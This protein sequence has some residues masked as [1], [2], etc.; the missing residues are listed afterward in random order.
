MNE[1]MNEWM[2]ELYCKPISDETNDRP[3]NKTLL[4]ACCFVTKL[5]NECNKNMKYTLL[6]FSMPI[7]SSN[8]ESYDD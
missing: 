6:N 2:N 3:L 1:W 8:P 4:N 7:T 5:C